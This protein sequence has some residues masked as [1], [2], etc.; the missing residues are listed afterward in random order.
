MERLLFSFRYI[1][2]IAILCSTAGSILMFFVGTLKTYKAFTIILFG[3]VPRESLSSLKLTDAAATSLIQSLDAFLFALVLLIF[4]YGVYS[5]FISKHS[6]IDESG[7]LKWLRIPSI[8]H[9]KNTLAEVIIIILFVNFLE[10][11]LLSLHKLTWELLVLPGSI[12][13][14]ALSLKFLGLRGQS[15]SKD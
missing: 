5:L 13:L 8:A 1:S 10:I 3:K 7:T 14:L 11:A 6:G 12:L 15:S 9:L 2:W 4:S